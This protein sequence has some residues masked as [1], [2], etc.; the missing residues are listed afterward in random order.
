MIFIGEIILNIILGDIDYEMEKRLP[1]QN[2]ARLPH[3]IFIPIFSKN[4]DGSYNT[5]LDEI[6]NQCH[7]MAPPIERSYRGGEPIPFS[8]G[9]I[10]INEDGRF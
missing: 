8:G 10:H 6:F 1:K 2:Y 7:F 9:L 4:N 3:S 5:A